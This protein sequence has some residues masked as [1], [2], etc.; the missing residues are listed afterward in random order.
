MLLPLFS[1]VSLLLSLSSIA[2]QGGYDPISDV[3]SSPPEEN[4]FIRR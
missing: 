4:A 3:Q 1:V 2:V